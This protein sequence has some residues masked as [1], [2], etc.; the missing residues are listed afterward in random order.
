MRDQVETYDTNIK[1]HFTALREIVDLLDCDLTSINSMLGDNDKVIASNLHLYLRLLET[2]L[3][4]M[5]AFIY[6]DERDGMDLLLVSD[7]MVVESLKRDGDEPPVKLDEVIIT[8]E[9]PECGELED[10]NRFDDKIVHCLDEEGLQT[11]VAKKYEM[12]E[13]ETRLHNLLSCN[14]PRSGVIASRRYAE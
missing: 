5:L 14:L 13:T 2:R 11:A 7:G 12:P 3:N 10:V 8:S 6:C 9:C 1:S 4:D